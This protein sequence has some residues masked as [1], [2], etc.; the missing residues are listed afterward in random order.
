MPS[1]S[2]T[3]HAW[4]VLPVT[5][6]TSLMSSESA[7]TADGP[8]PTTR[9]GV[10]SETDRIARAYEGLESRA[11]WRWSLDNPGNRAALAERR[12]HGTRLLETARMLPFGER[13]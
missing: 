8:I 12:R 2:A 5:A 6:A 10:V 13:R 11:G 7:P 9:R 3:P 4:P 1:W